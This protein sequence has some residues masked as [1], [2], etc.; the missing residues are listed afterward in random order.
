MLR[1]RIRLFCTLGV[2]Y[3]LNAVKILIVDDHLLFRQGLASLLHSAPDFEVS[4]QAGTLR[5]AVDL[6][7]QIKPDIVLMD[8]GLPD[9]KGPEAAKAILSKNP[10][11]RVVF[12]TVHID[13]EDLFAAVRSGAKGYLLKDTPI[14]LL[15]DNLRAVQN[16]RTAMSPMMTGRILQEFA[17]LGAGDGKQHE[18]L[19]SLTHREIEVLHELALGSSN[20]EIAQKLFMAENTV[21]RHVHN[22][23]LKLDVSNR[24]DSGQFCPGARSHIVVSF[25]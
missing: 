14:T 18:A 7:S 20:R 5:E 12:L 8:Y 22:I 4:G 11:C 21:K 15:L 10:S 19:A 13:D 17:R 6:A 2:C 9:G 25:S 3:N 1:T 23:L 16:G 24:R